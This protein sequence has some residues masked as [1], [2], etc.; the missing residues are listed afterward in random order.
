ME[1]PGCWCHTELLVYLCSFSHQCSFRTHPRSSSGCRSWWWHI[2]A[3]NSSAG[4]WGAALRM[5]TEQ[6]VTNIC[7]IPKSQTLETQIYSNACIRKKAPSQFTM[8]GIH[9][10]H[11]PPIKSLLWK[12]H[13]SKW[14]IGNQH[15]I[16]IKSC[17]KAYNWGVLLL[18]LNIH[19]LHVSYNYCW[20]K[21]K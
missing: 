8:L 16:S 15:F 10:T 7:A 11:T 3:G 17:S 12:L 13:V 5:G 6:D 19:F 9:H 4:T 2:C 20:G 18:R 14:N 1:T 21:K